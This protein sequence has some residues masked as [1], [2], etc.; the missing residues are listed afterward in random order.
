M[1]SF[2]MAPPNA[3]LTRMPE[4]CAPDDCFEAHVL[5]HLDK[6][7][8]LAVRMNNRLQDLKTRVQYLD[9][10]V[11]HIKMEQRKRKAED[12]DPDVAQDQGKAA[13]K[14]FRTH[15]ECSFVN[16]EDF[17]L[18]STPKRSNHGV[19]DSPVLAPTIQMGSAWSNGEESEG[20]RE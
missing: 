8:D 13:R 15:P 20:G 16:A 1:A 7:L 2:S 6:I 12:V 4:D 14:F 17:P 5:F 11:Q 18:V 3:T 19:V 9:F 10:E